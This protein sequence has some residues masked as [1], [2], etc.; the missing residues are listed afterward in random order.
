MMLGLSISTLQGCP[1]TLETICKG[2]NNSG[3]WGEDCAWLHDAHPG[4][5]Y[6]GHGG[7]QEHDIVLRQDAWKVHPDW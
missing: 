1:C 7:M 5:W 4:W 6:F 2:A 3:Y